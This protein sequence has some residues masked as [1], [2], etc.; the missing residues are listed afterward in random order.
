[1]EQKTDLNKLVKKYQPVVKKTGEQLAKAVKAAE[2][3]IAKMYRVAQVHVE[4]QMKNLQKERLYHEIGKYVAGKIMKGSL[5]A[6]DLERFKKR[7]DKIDAEGEKMKKALARAGK[8]L[9]GKKA[10]KKK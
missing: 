2:E 5:D 4:I 3:D 9:K 6:S 8:A 10:A 7:L 1:M